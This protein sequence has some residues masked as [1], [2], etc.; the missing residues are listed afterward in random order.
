MRFEFTNHA[1]QRFIERHAPEMSAETAR[2][3]LTDAATH[4]AAKIKS[5]SFRGDQQWQLRN[6]DVVLVTTTDDG[7]IIVKTVLP[8]AHAGLTAYEAEIVSDFLARPS[9]AAKLQAVQPP[10]NVPKR[11]SPAWFEAQKLELEIKLVK[12]A[13]KLAD[14]S[15]KRGESIEA[16][17]LAVE[18]AR[19][20]AATQMESER[21]AL[22]R[23]RLRTERHAASMEGRWSALTDVARLALT[24]LR[25]VDPQFEQWRAGL[26]G[27][28]AELAN[29]PFFCGTGTPDNVN[30]QG[31]RQ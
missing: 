25:E 13:S 18:R 22:E 29:K 27:E 28:A 6:P 16:N 10:D 20:H 15:A 31:D 4:R 19:I 21:I 23:D 9:V 1:I 26:T 24:R 7:R 2:E 14:A 5:R 3:L 8:K 30:P 12:L 11:P 17:R